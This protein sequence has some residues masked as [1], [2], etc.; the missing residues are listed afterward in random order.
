MY[1]NE[2]VYVYFGRLQSEPKPD[3]AEIA[4]IAHLSV[5]AI[6]RRIRREPGA[7]AFW[8]KHY[9]HNH[10]GEIARLAQRVSRL[11]PA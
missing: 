11:P 4:N 5:D 10:S 3:P 9:F 2:F 6:A 8:F 1:E 7:F